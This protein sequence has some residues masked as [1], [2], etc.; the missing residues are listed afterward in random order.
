MSSLAGFINFAFSS[1]EKKKERKE[2][3]CLFKN[4]PTKSMEINEYNV[5]TRKCYKE[6]FQGVL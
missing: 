6:L 3:K 4:E 2:Y 1:E 5:K